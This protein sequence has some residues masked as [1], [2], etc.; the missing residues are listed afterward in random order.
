VSA[1]TAAT[2]ELRYEAKARRAN[3]NQAFVRSLLARKQPEFAR[4]LALVE[5]ELESCQRRQATGRLT[6]SLCNRVSTGQS[7]GGSRPFAGRQR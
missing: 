1:L 6:C 3:E 7:G 4:A 2:S 5:R